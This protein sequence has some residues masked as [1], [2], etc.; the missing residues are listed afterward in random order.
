VWVE[1][2][3]VLIDYLRTFRRTQP[4]H[5][6]VGIGAMNTGEGFGPLPGKRR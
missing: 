3:R 5:P 6:S 4:G 1:G 2:T